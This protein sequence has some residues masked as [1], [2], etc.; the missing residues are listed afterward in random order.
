MEPSS[1][2]FTLS[3]DERTKTQ[4]TGAA[5]W[6]RVFAYAG[7]ATLALII[8]NGIYSSNSLLWSNGEAESGAEKAGEIIGML[9]L[10]LVPVLSFVFV[11]RF[12]NAVQKAMATDDQHVLN[13]SVRHL[14]IYFRYT[15]VLIILFALLIAFAFTLRFV[16]SRTGV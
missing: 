6:D 4:L 1:T 5:K 15:A 12:A 13:R 2:L 7:M 16:S 10:V 8:A 11:L 3:I 9:L 14:K